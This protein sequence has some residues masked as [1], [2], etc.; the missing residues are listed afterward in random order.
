MISLRRA[1]GAE[2][3]SLVDS[4]YESQGGGTRAREDDLLFLAHAGE[5]LVGAVRF[6]VEEGHPMLRGMMIR[7]DKRGQG[8]GAAMLSDFQG[9]LEENALRNVLCLP[10]DYLTRFYGQI[11]FREARPAEIPEFLVAR[12]AQYNQKPRKVT[13]MIRP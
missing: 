5:E 10:Y 8:I 6:C 7:E 13:C 9:Y 2:V 12:M 11:G 3:K 1:P 4:F